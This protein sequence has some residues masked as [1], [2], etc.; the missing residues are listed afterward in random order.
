MKTI[1]YTKY[2]PPDVLHF[3]EAEKPKPEGNEIQVRIIATA[4]NSGDIRLRKADPFAVRFI[5]GLLKPK[6]KV[7]GSVYS[8]V[9]EEIG[10]D[11]TRFKV[12]DE[13]FGHTDMRFGAYAEYKCMPEDGTVA[14]KPANISHIEAAVVPFGGLAALHFIKR[15][16]IKNGQKVLIYGASGAVGTAA[17]QLAKYYGAIVTGV[18]GTDNVGLVRSLGADM[19]IDYSKEDITKNG[20]KYDVIFDTVNKI[21]FHK[22]LKSLNRTGII[23][24]SAAGMTEMIKGLW[25]SI[26]SGRTVLTGV[27]RHSKE[28]LNFLKQLIETR[29]FQPVVDRVYTLAEIAI[30]HAYVEK[31]HKKEMLQ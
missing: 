12:G 25:T 17:V 19:V 4:V 3:G 18:C 22:I 8:G 2:G 5:F 23:I 30:A 27:I 15:A 29:R 11:V 10:K 7:L 14:L 26:T 20:E 28:D 1:V 9:V 21:P 6:I 24:L 13:A 31:G 16:K